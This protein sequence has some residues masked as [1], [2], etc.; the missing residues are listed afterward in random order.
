MEL[1]VRDAKPLIDIIRAVLP[2][3]HDLVMIVAE[4]RSELRQT[5]FGSTSLRL[6]RECPCPVGVIKPYLTQRF[7]RIRAAVD[8][9]PSDAART[10]VI[11]QIIELGTSLVGLKDSELHVVDAWHVCDRTGWGNWRERVPQAQV[12][13]W[14]EQTPAAHQ[15]RFEEP[16]GQFTLRAMRHRLHLV[17]GD[18]GTV[19]PELAGL[20][21]S[22][23]QRLLRDLPCCLLTVRAF[24]ATAASAPAQAEQTLSSANQEQKPTCARR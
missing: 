1:E 4:G 3:Q 13:D 19:T 20:L 11:S 14:V 7:A 5:L 12:D 23:V 8:R 18:A 10:G 2:R 21:G 22:N 15:P 9:D 24:T 16:L 6:M 17:K